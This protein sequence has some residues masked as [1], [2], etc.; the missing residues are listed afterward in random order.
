MTRDTQRGSIL[1]VDDNAGV[2]EFVKSFLG[3]AGYA[4]IAA[5]DGEEGLHFFEEHQSTIMLVLTDVPMPRM[6]G[7]ELAD[8][9]LAIKPQLR[10]L[11]MSGDAR[12]AYRGLRC[13]SKPFGATEPR[14]SRVLNVTTHSE[15]TTA[16]AAYH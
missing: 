7:F 14:V 10:I 12:C 2:R 15:R 16:S 9:L 6:N 4:V 8:Y 11:F 1:V 5:A 3:G 13:V